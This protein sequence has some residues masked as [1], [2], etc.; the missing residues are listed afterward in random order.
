MS[1][2]FRPV[3][4]TSPK[5]S[6]LRTSLL[7]MNPAAKRMNSSSRERSVMLVPRTSI[8]N[9]VYPSTSLEGKETPSIT[10]RSIERLLSHF[11]GFVFLSPFAVS[12]SLLSVSF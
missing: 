4:T 9:E 6:S 12:P 1:T 5:K 3:I 11:P 2:L 7:Q 8:P 10:T